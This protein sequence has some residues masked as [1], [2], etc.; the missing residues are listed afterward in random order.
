MITMS[1]GWV[2]W[3]HIIGTYTGVV[4]GVLYGTYTG[5]IITPE[6]FEETSGIIFTDEE[7]STLIAERDTAVEIPGNVN[8]LIMETPDFLNKLTQDEMIAILSASKMYIQIELLIFKL[9][10]AIKI[11]LRNKKLIE[12]IMALQASGL[13]TE[14]RAKEIL[15]MKISS[16]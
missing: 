9:Q 2:Q 3:D 14:N 12:G 13:L 16:V 4:N 1:N 7:K 8:P 10:N 11:D 5:S 15:G 6:A